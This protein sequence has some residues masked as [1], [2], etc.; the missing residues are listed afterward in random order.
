M[1]GSERTAEL[2]PRARRK[3][4]TPIRN[5]RQDPMKLKHVV[6]DEL[7]CLHIR[8]K[9]GKGDEVCCFRESFNSV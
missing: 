3:L 8:Q 4:R 2:L 7:G 6:C 1:T 9:L 5:Y